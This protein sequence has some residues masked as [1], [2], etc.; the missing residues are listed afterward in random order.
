ML[1]WVKKNIIVSKLQT[2]FDDLL[3]LNDMNITVVFCQFLE[4]FVFGKK[5]HI[6]Q[7]SEGSAVDVAT[8]INQ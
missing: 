4:P 1:I 8:A 6:L 2:I 3:Q 7:Y 5:P